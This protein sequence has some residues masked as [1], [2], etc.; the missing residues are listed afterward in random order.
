MLAIWN[1]F[2]R[3]VSDAAPAFTVGLILSAG[4]QWLVARSHW[5]AIA[6]S[7]VAQSVPG[8]ALA[9]AALP[10]CS[11]TTVPLAI[12]LKRQGAGDG[13]LLA[14]IITS[15][16]LGPASIVLTFTMFGPAWGVL[17]LALP[18][19]A[20]CGLG[21]GLQRFG[22]KLRSDG[23]D[24]DEASCSSACG[25]ESGDSRCSSGEDRSFWANLLSMT[26]NLVPILLLGLLAAAV[27]SVLIGKE[28]IEQWMGGGV[29]A[30]VAA[31]V[32]GLPAYVCEGGE[33]P[34]T[35]ALVT[36][37][38]GIGPAFT[39]M[40]ASVGTCLPTLMML[41]KLI[42]VKLTVAYLAFWLVYSLASGILVGWIL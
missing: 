24:I 17:R 16:L 4:V 7:W 21:W 1:E 38:V 30:Y 13:P 36:M 15:A 14:F 40:Q 12:P 22:K 5:A 9:G 33:V 37:G 32:A 35:A 41:P 31:V 2:V 27:A 19:I 10:G 18:L 25:C 26:R 34:L 3:F 29:W 28:Q 6:L 20:V 23:G 8:A 11:M 42:G 39:F